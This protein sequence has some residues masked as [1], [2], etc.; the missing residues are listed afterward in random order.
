MTVKAGYTKNRTEAVID[1]KRETAME[2]KQFLGC[3]MPH[4]PAFAMPDQPAK[5]VKIDLA[6]ASI[7]YKTPEGQADF[8]S[9]RHTFITNLAR[10]GVHPSDAQALA[11]HSSITLTMDCYTHKVRADLRKIID[12]QPDLTI[13]ESKNLSYA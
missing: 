5:M 6:A 2:L 3:K 1:L 13:A 11:R 4:L 9:L 12:A 8:H 10:A 7:D